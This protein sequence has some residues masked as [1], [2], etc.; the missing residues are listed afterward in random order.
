MFVLQ[1]AQEQK[2]VDILPLSMVTYYETGDDNG[3][4]PEV[5]KTVRNSYGNIWTSERLKPPALQG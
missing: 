4:K 2:S 5:V 1:D 3:Q